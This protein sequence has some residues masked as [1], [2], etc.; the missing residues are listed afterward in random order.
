MPPVIHY[1]KHVFPFMVFYEAESF[2][3]QLSMGILSW[4]VELFS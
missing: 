2:V 3:V 1:Q 4:Y